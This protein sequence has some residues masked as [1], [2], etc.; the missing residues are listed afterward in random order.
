MI[1]EDENSISGFCKGSE[2]HCPSGNEHVHLE[3]CA[4]INYTMNES[5]RQV[6]RSS[7][8]IIITNFRLQSC[9]AD[10]EEKLPVVIITFLWCRI[11]DIR[12][13]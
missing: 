12:T 8:I 11:F 3:L 7:G 10:K 1:Q 13:I 6:R 4:R 9:A 2:L 5:D